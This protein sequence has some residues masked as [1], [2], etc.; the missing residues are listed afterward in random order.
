MAIQKIE[1]QWAV[2]ELPDKQHSQFTEVNGLDWHCCLAG[3]SKN[4]PQ[5]FN[6]FS[7]AMGAKPLF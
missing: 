1:I 7:I 5:N 4:G 2:L 6:F 3:S